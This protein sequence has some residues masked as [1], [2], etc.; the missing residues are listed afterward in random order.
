MGAR[1]LLVAFHLLLLFALACGDEC[2]RKITRRRRFYSKEIK[3]FKVE[4]HFGSVLVK[5]HS[6]D[7]D[8]RILVEVG[9]VGTLQHAANPPISFTDNG[10]EVL[11]MIGPLAADS[12]SRK[13]S[14]F[15]TWILSL[16][17]F[18]GLVFQRRSF[19]V[20]T[21]FL[22]SI[23]ISVTIAQDGCPSG[24]VELF[25]P[26]N[27]CFSVNSDKDGRSTSVDIITC[28]AENQPQVLSCSVSGYLYS[29]CTGGN[30]CMHYITT[31]I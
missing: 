24:D 19:A 4:N 28:K 25:M 7:S 16:P 20:V 21:L 3:T 2:T 23:W 15:N 6:S 10:E 11:I 5:K 13:P 29:N 8:A 14:L 12:S 26:R 30:V 9:L 18:A 27:S 31:V 22:F 1:Q 17:L